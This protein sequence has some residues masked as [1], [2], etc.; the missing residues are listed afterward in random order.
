M[1]SGAQNLR[2][3][4]KSCITV[5]KQPKAPCAETPSLA[6]IWSPTGP[7]QRTSLYPRSDHLHI[8]R[9]IISLCSPRRTRTKRHAIPKTNNRVSTPCIPQPI[10]LPTP[11]NHRNLHFISSCLSFFIAG[12]VLFYSLLQDTLFYSTACS[13]CWRDYN[14]LIKKKVGDFDLHALKDKIK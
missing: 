3:A 14:C 7:E 9:L 4:I 6:L 8:F 13:R 1:L 11:N 12:L 2:P 5:D 10:P